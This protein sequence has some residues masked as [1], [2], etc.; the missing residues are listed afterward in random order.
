[1]PDEI[2]TSDVVEAALEPLEAES[3]GTRAKSRT[4]DELLKAQAAAAGQTAVSG[5]RSAWGATRPGRFVPPAA[6]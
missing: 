6:S 3:D 1:M 2:T 4:I 5:S